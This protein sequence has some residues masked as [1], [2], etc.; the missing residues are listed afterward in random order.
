MQQE[1]QQKL[2]YSG[3]LLKDDLLLKDVLRQYEDD[4]TTHTM[5]LVCAGLDHLPVYS[6]SP[7]PK[8]TPAESSSQI[9]SSSDGLRQRSTSTVPS[10]HAPSETSPAQSQAPPSIAQ[11]Y[12]SMHQMYQGYVI[13]TYVPLYI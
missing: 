3:R 8:P 10:S 4:Q 6:P 11:Q 13:E 7:Q 2:I 12:A 1:N 5:H 9:P